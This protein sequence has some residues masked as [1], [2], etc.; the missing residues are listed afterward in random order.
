MLSKETKKKID[1]A[2]DI[3]VG[4]LPLPSDQV[5]LITI[6]LIYKFMDDQDE[7][8]RQLGYGEAFFTDELRDYSWQRLMSNEIDAEERVALF[9]KGIEEIQ[10]AGHIPQ[11]FREIFK[12]TFLKFRDG[13]TLFLFLGVINGF[14]YD[15]GEELGNAFEYLLMSMGAQGENGQ[16]RTPRNIIDFIVE[17]VDPDK[18]D[19]ILDPAG[20]TAG[21]LLAAYKHILRKYTTGMEHY[22]VTLNNEGIEGIPVNWGD[23]LTSQD[24]ERLGNSI[25]GYDITPLM[26]RIARVN[27]YL[28]QFKTP[29]VHEYDTLTSDGRWKDKFDCI[30]TNP[31][32]M[33]PKGGVKPHSRFRI[34]ANKAE[35]LF[36][37]YILEHLTP[38]GMAGFIVPEGI[39]FQN[40]GDYVEL[41]KW[42]VNDAGLWAVVS[43]PA[44]VF[45]PYS[46]VKTSIIFVDRKV[47]RTRDEIILLKV[48]HD[49]YSLNTNRTPVTRNELPE[50]LNLLTIGKKSLA[51]MSDYLERNSGKP[52]LPKVLIKPRSEFARLDAYRAQT[53]AF[54]LIRKQYEKC[55]AL[56]EEIDNLPPLE[57]GRNGDDVKKRA[58]LQTA[59][60]KQSAE[61][62][63]V[64]GARYDSLNPESDIQSFFDTRLKEAVIAFGSDRSRT[65]N[66]SVPLRGHL[67]GQREYNLS[68]DKYQS[69]V[70]ID[71]Q[72]PLVKL[73]EI[74]ENLDSKR[75]PITKRDRKE[76][77]YPYYGASGI[78]DYVDNYIFDEELLLISED[79][80]NL[81]ARSTPIAFSVSGK[82]WVNNH[83]HVLRFSEMATQ[84]FVEIYINSISIDN[85][86]TGS[87]QPKLNQQALNSIR[88]P[89]P[90]LEILQQIVAEIEAYQKKIE[91]AKQQVLDAEANIRTIIG[92]VWGEEA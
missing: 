64:A 10:K 8:L 11:L 74:C 60:D 62:L 49:G 87:A 63:K 78:V 33:T 90:P 42:L 2:R 48:E 69:T 18:G 16:F 58:R 47:A 5:E 39:I 59:F 92:K 73:G 36:S 4:Q 44:H 31:P 67:D 68:F 82:I 22:R 21:F 9:I 26:V 15:H 14:R 75:V 91:D 55:L 29:R 50:A 53:A 52:D 88:I 77:K 28:H 45:Q 61:F 23:R 85:Y 20:G 41:R 7:D 35:V 1:D 81:L 71:E 46:G 84:K 83:A 56:E 65:G 57:E 19:S 54:S 12:N 30:L 80:A 32:F 40:S 76:G 66:L 27:L 38:D 72:W 43:L 25:E 37:D 86:V 24:L 51:D 13:R 70:E 17:V 79:G 6:A 3:L 89:L 34:R